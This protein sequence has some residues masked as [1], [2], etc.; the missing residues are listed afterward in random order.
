MPRRP[1]HAL[2]QAHR[3]GGDVDG[4]SLGDELDGAL[5]TTVLRSDRRRAPARVNNLRCAE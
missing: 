3:L 1:Q 2:A 4:F 5:D